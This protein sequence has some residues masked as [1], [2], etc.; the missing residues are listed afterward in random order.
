MGWRLLRRTGGLRAVWNL[1][2]RPMGCG[3]SRPV[4][5][6]SCC[7]QAA[8]SDP[9]AH[10]TNSIL[11]YQIESFTVRYYNLSVVDLME[12]YWSGGPAWRVW[13]F[14][15]SIGATLS[16]SQRNFAFDPKIKGRDRSVGIAARYGLDGPRSNP[17]G[18]EIFRTR[19]DGPWGPPS[20]LYDG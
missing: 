18:G 7:P 20:L 9:S 12:A 14:F 13:F 3:T 1:F 10:S 5:H 6:V 15:N 11:T 16:F 4:F 19:L 17:G 8:P 2:W